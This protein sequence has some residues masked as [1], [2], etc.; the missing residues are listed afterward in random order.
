MSRRIAIFDRLSRPL[1]IVTQ[2]GILMVILMA[3]G[4]VGFIEY[5]GQPSFCTNCH[6]MQPYYDSWATSSHNTVKCI[7]CHYA[8]GIKAEA[9][10]KLQAANQV[11]KYVT[12]AYG[13]KPWAEVEDAACLRSGC[14]T[15]RELEGELDFEGVRFDHSHHLGELR[16]GKRLRCTSCHSQIVQGSPL[17]VEGIEIGAAHLRVTSV[18]CYLCHFKDRPAGQPL[19]G[20]L[21]CHEDPPRVRSDA[22]FV[23]NHAEYV[24]NLVSCVGCHETVTSGTGEA[25]QRRCFNCHNEPERIQ[26]VENT[27]LVHQVHIAMHNVECTQCHV[28][29]L[30]RVVS[31]SETFE[32]DCDACHQRVHQ[33]QREMYAGLGGHGTDN[34]PS[35]MFLARVSCQSCHGIPANIAGHEN[36]NRA[37]EATCM[38]CHGVRYANI[39]PAWQQEIDRRRRLVNTIVSD[40]RQTLGGVPLRQRAAA[41]SLLRLA[42]ENI[43]FVER[44]RGA[45]NIA[46]ADQLLR[47]AID[48]AREAA[49]VGRLSYSVPEVDL[50][51]AIGR[52][53][54]LQCHVD[55]GEQAGTF[56][57]GRFDH[58]PHVLRSDIACTECHTP[59]DQHGEITLADRSS[60][61]ACHH[62]AIE[63]LN[64]AQ[65][66]PGPGGAPTQPIRTDV[67]D[68]PHASH[69][70]AGLSCIACHKAPAMSAA[71]LDC[72][73][74]HLIH[75]QTD[76][77][78]LSC[79]RDG[80]KSIHPAAAHS[81]CAICHGDGAAFITEWTRQVC[82]VCHSDKVD[83]NPP[84][85]CHL[86]HTMPAPT[87]G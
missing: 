18:T 2:V 62:R 17:N 66:H 31:L 41:D 28:P 1:K 81:G 79:H 43:D 10:G 56:A 40:A 19:A 47:A 11:V 44:G 55:I 42:Q 23:V 83:H 54:C 30:H 36:V 39:L 21:G 3:I 87:G 6:I 58:E 78:C 59:L 12:G 50:G 72:M 4:T 84:A 60:C 46:Y 57:G 27:T 38:S 73:N 9:M 29:I 34:M 8:P 15:E 65:C 80:V 82:T 26:E 33:E 69:T 75:H 32:L 49:E 64:C 51:P 5:S 85:A 37:G 53:V 71:S 76:N 7:E 70:G 48:L 22:G 74:C 13:M 24:E 45:H 61:E 67:G 20:C 14:H 25:G 63:P 86:C 77:S 52:N 68:F 16:R 35:S